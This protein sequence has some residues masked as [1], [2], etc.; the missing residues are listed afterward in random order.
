MEALMADPTVDEASE[1]PSTE[2]DARAIMR[3]LV[4]NKGLKAG[5]SMANAMILA[6]V[7]ELGIDGI[8]QDEALTFA[9]DK[10]WLE[11]RGKGF[12]AVTE[13]GY[14]AGIAEDA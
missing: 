7:I 10:A 11:S 4:I 13:A 1:R 5:D 3:M 9:G 14:A 6:N 8:R 12:T 2:E